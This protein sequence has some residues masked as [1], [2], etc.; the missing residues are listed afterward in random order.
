LF[1]FVDPSKFGLPPALST[2]SPKKSRVTT[3]LYIP[4]FS[5]L[6]FIKLKAVE[7][8]VLALCQI[9]IKCLKCAPYVDVNHGL[10]EIVIDLDQELD[11]CNIFFEWQMI[12]S[13]LFE[14][15]K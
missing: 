13:S 1:W 6:F 5:Q 9:E 14:D 3:V 8:K 11:G 15:A 12:L 4:H 7:I 10:L 2:N